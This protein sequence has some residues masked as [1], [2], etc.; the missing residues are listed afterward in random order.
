[1]EK[2]KGKQG[3]RE[4]KRKTPQKARQIQGRKWANIKRRGGKKRTKK[5]KE[6]KVTMP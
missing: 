1:V 3:K 6:R 5:K 2:E 4:T